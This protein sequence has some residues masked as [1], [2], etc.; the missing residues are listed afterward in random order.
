MDVDPH[1][2]GNHSSR[3]KVLEDFTTILIYSFSILHRT[4]QASPRLL[5]LSMNR[6]N[7]VYLLII[8]VQKQ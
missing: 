8:M 4:I 2:F 6:Q 1:A 7:N 3:F 5:L